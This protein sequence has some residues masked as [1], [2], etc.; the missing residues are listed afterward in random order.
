MASIG[1]NVS[2][3]CPLTEGKEIDKDVDGAVSFAAF[4][5]RF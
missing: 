4:G 5:M 3:G 2:V 1:E